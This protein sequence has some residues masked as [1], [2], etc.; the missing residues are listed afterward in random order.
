M[1]FNELLGV[2]A[3]SANVIWAVGRFEP[4]PSFFETLTLHWTG[5]SWSVVPSP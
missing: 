5:I 3:V 2:T 4:S 1:Q